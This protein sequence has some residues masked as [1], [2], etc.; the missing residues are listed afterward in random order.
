MTSSTAADECF[1]SLSVCRVGETPPCTRCILQLRC[2][3]QVRLYGF[4]HVHNIRYDYQFGFR[5]NHS[6]TLALIVDEIFQHLDKD[7]I[8]IG[9]YL[10]LKKAFDTDDHNILLY[11]LHNYGIRCIIYDWFI[12]YLC[13]RR[14]YTCIGPNCSEIA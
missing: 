14:Q 11:K 9:I 6:T 5:K 12:S 10:D 7:E 3:L 4:L 8:G 13:N 2:I 1:H